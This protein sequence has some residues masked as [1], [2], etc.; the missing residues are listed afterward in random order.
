M[1]ILVDSW[2]AVTKETVNN[3]FKNAGINSDVQQAAFDVSDNQFKDLQENLNELKS[4]DPSMVLEDV[5][6]ESIA[7]FGDDD[8][9]TAPEIAETDIIV[10]LC[11]SQ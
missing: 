9:A 8:R 6:A 2:E 1:K 5:T 11:F 4:A 3:C 7:S 10:E